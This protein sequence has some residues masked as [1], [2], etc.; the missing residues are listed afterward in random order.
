MAWPGLA[1]KILIAVIGGEKIFKEAKKW[2]MEKV[3]PIEGSIVCCGLLGGACD[4]SGVY[5][6]NGDIVH[7]S[8][9]GYLEVVSPEAF[10]ARH[11]GRNPAWRIHVS[12]RGESAVGNDKARNRALQAVNNHNHSEYSGYHL[13]KKNCHHFCQYC[14]TG[15]KSEEQG[16]MYFTFTSLEQTLKDE[17]Q[18]DKWRVWDVHK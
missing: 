13:Q 18:F 9:G 15:I 10:L 4:H 12:C 14:L 1:L 8:G 6:G 2:F 5:V 11:S 7:R 3:Q 17:C 16:P